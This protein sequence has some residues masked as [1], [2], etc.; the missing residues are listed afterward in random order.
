MKDHQEILFPAKKDGKSGYINS[1]GEVVLDFE[2]DFFGSREFTEGLASVLV[3]NKAGYIDIKGNFVIK[4]QFDMAMPFSEGLAYVS[5]NGKQGYI[6]KSGQF[7][8]PAIY[9]SCNSFND[10]YALVNDTVTSKGSFINKTG[11]TKLTGRNFLIS[12][13][14]EG[15]VNCTDNKGN[16]GFIDIDGNTVIDYH[17]K[18]TR[19]FYEGLAAVT[20]KKEIDGKP[21]L[22][23]KVGFINRQGDLI[24]S[25]IFEGGDMKFSDGLCSIWHRDKDTFGYIDSKGEIIIPCDFSYGD[26]FSE[27]MAAFT[28]KGKNKKYGYINKRGEVIIEPKF[29]AIESFENGLAAVIIGKEYDKF[30]Y[31]YVNKKG[32]YVWEPRR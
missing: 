15:L 2:F 26:H 4:P 14:K 13:Y 8:I 9:Y 6:D 22:K 28:P 25:Q 30:L 32:E 16:W 19:P 5:H 27:G 24:I 7:V 11:E 23:E 31:G 20:P 29:T 3:N 21:N 17:Y 1:S 12:E 10:G 18:L